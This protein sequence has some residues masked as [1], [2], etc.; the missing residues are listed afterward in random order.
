MKIFSSLILMFFIAAVH[1]NAQDTA[2]ATGS[3]KVYGNCGMCKATIEKAATS[4]KGVESAVWDV[5]SDT[6]TVIY[7][8]KKTDPDKILQAI[9]DKG[10]DSDTHRA[11]TKAYNNL[12]GC[13]QYDRPKQ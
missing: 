10:Y 7:N 13:C 2:L 8:I 4:V 5:T 12:P 9:A 11:T 6:I 1:T 3:Y